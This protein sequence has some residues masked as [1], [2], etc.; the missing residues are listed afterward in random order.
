[1]IDPGELV[2][3]TLR[4]E[5]SEE[6][7][8][9][10]EMSEDRR[11]AMDQAIA[12]LFHDGVTVSALFLSSTGS[13]A[14]AVLQIYKGHVDDPRNTDNAW[15]ETVA[16]NFHDEQGESVGML[17]LQAG[18]DAAKVQW[19]DAHSGLDLYASH[20]SMLEKVVQRLSA[21]W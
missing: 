17:R 11:R 14:Y 3:T 8:N 15:M 4:R 1:M 18:D 16:V 9:S 21:H 5:F 13:S 10:K 20:K 19:C 12:A 2:S 6:A 7:L